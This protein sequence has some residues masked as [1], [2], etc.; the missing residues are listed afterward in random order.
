MTYLVNEVP[1]PGGLIDGSG[2]QYEFGGILM[3]TGSSIVMDSVEGLDSMPDITSDDDDRNDTHGSYSGVDLMQ[4]RVIEMDIDLLG[5]THALTLT[6][7]RQLSKATR[8]RDD[9]LLR[10]LVFQRP[11]EPKRYCAVKPRRR[12][13]PSNYEL[14]HGLAKGKLQFYAPDPRIYRLAES[15]KTITILD[16]TSQR[17]SELT[18]L[19]DFD[20]LPVLTVTGA[21]SN[22]RITNEDNGNRTVKWD[23]VMDADDVLVIDFENRTATLNGADAYS[24]KRGDNQWWKLLDGGNT[25]QVNRTGVVGPQTYEFRWHDAWI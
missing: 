21:G 3:G 25:I 13:F 4:A 23:V 15:T 16:G 2:S 14:A 10:K 11:G 9:A 22:L 19:G 5:S 20:T 6:S 18:T 12:A 1:A 7:I 17:T 24:F 8:P